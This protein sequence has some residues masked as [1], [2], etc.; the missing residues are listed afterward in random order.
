MK[1]IIKDYG[2]YI[3]ILVIFSLLYFIKLPYYVMAPGGTIKLNNRIEVNN[4]KEIDGSI[5]ML[6]VTQYDATITTYIVAK[7]FRNWDLEDIEKS[8]INNESMDEIG[9]RNKIMLDNSIQNA[10]FVAY[11]KA[12]K[13]IKINGSTSY[14]VGTTVD[15]NLK[16]GDIVL[17]VDGVSID[18]IKDVQKIVKDKEVGDSVKFKIIRNDKEIEV[19]NKV[20]DIDG[21]KVVG[22]MIITNYDYEIDPEIK[23]KFRGK[24]SGASG[25]L[26][27]ALTIYDLISDED[28]VKGRNISGTGTINIDGSVGKIDGIKYKI[29]G[30]VKDKMD[31]VLVPGGN[32]EEAIKVKKDMNYDIDIIKVSNIDEAIEYLKNN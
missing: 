6:Y 1:K 19:N 22:A 3:I 29:M 27:L 11:N 8:Q 16:V 13:D 31:L 18:N 9:E 2:F 20:Q 5:N 10:I 23:L 7:V 28:I 15:N 12:G 26:M 32:Y 4:D 25:G 14:V 30:A 17:E 24:E 21:N